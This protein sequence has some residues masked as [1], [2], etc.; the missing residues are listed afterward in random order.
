MGDFYFETRN[1]DA[2][3]EQYRAAAH[4]FPASG[5]IKKKIVLATYNVGVQFIKRHQYPEAL[6]AM[7]KVL[8]MD[9]HN[10]HATKKIVQLR[11]ILDKQKMKNKQKEEAKHL[12]NG[13]QDVF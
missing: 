3:L 5:R 7:E 2:A 13:Q 6:G 8:E 1:Y 11:R 4:N 9:A 10:R 12:E